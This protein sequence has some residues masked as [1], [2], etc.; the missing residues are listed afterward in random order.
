MS[1]ARELVYVEDQYLW[2]HHIGN[3]FTEALN[4]HPD[5]RVIAV[6]PLHPDT[7]GLLSRTPELLGRR[8]AMRQM[9]RAAPDRVAVYGLENAHGTPIYVHAK[10]CVVDDTW[11]TIGSDNFNRRSWTHDSELSVAVLDREPAGEPHSRYGRRLRLRLAAEHLGREVEDADLEEAMADC[12]APEDAFR[13]FA[14]AAEALDEWHRSGRV[15]PR[16]P[17]QL[18][19]MQPPD[20]SLGKRLFAAVPYLLLHDPDGRPRRLRKADD[21]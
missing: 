6:V 4:G 21:Y 2:G 19:R 3:V 15:G 12:L 20:L 5:V 18:R 9:I 17:G 16:P 1:N 13:T 14:E 7:E 8:R 11:A 10:T